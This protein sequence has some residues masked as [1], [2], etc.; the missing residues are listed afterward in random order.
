MK[1]IISSNGIARLLLTGTIAVAILISCTSANAQTSYAWQLGN[2]SWTIITNWVPNGSPDGIDNTITAGNP[3]GSRTITLDGDHTI[4]NIS[5]TINSS[6][7]YT[8]NSGTPS[9][10]ILT[11]QDSLTVPSV[12][13]GAGATSGY[14]L[15]NA[16]LAGTQGFTKTGVGLFLLG[17]VDTITGAIN[18]TGTGTGSASGGWLVD[19]GSLPVGAPVQVNNYGSLAGTGTILDAVTLNSGGKIDPGPAFYNSYTAG[20]LTASALTWN[21]GGAMTYELAAAGATSDSLALTGALTKGTAGTY[22]F[23]FTQNTGFSTS[24]IYTLMTFGSNSGFSASNF[25]GAPAGMQFQLTDTSLLLVPE[26][27]AWAMML[28]GLGIF[29]A[30][31]RRW[32]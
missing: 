12:W 28:G 19:N 15:I 4:G 3:N 6:R 10:S 1:D 23:T 16:P 11:L 22:N 9:T 29:A 2:G 32:R 30:F 8:I 20:V 26:P 31:R 25:G 13:V 18:I 14:L 21:G 17:G 24:Q 7:S 5:F 27:A